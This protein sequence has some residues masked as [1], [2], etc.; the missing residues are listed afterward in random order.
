MITTFPKQTSLA[1]SVHPMTIRRFPA[2]RIVLLGSLLCAFH[3]AD[4]AAQLSFTVTPLRH[5]F[6]KTTVGLGSYTTNVYVTNTGSVDLTVASIA[7]TPSEFQLVT[8][9]F[10][11]TISPGKNTRFGVNFVPDGPKNFSGQLIINITGVSPVIVPLTG[12]GVST[13]AVAGLSS[14]S[15]MFANQTTGTTS[16]SQ[17]VTVSNLGTAPLTVET[18][19][20]DPPF[21]VQ[22]FT[23]P[24]TLQPG[25]AFNFNVT[26]T[27]STVGTFT[28][29]MVISYD[30]LPPNG[31]TLYGNGTA[32]LS[33]AV[34]NLPSLPWATVSSPYLATLTA[35][36]GTAPYSWSLASG[37]SLPLGLTLSSTGTIRGTLDP[38]VQTGS[39]GFDVFATDSSNP[40][41]A[42][43]APVTIPVGALTGADCGNTSWNIGHSTSPLVALNDLGTGTYLGAEA[44]LYPNGSNIRPAA[45]DAAGVAI[46]NSIQPLDGDGNPDPNGKYGLISIGE[47]NTSATFT[48]FTIDAN[49]DPS[50]NSHLTIVKGAQPTGYAANFA[51]PNSSFWNPIFQF[52]LPQAGLTANQVVAVWVQAVNAFPTGLFPSDMTQEQSQLESIAQNLHSKFPNLKLAYYTSKFYDGYDNGLR[53]P[54]YPEPYAY[55][56][57]FAVKWAIQDQIN[58]SAALNYDSNNGPVMAPWM[59]WGP[60]EWANGLLGRSDGLVWSC[61]DMTSDGVHPSSAIGV[62]KDANILLNFFKSDDTTAPWFLAH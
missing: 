45:D 54:R 44:G 55:E 29:A 25:S 4:A 18:I 60:Y 32:P 34:S 17:A 7:I 23:A 49:A 31:V 38:S 15:L 33:F 6:A 46:A 2:V 42:V 14:S 36:G 16:G 35:A 19:T 20:I 50:K 47:S 10:P 37:S 9:W 26:F 56:T 30:V 13:G 39:Y 22:G 1:R 43:T 58:G 61:Q 8:G 53:A 24:T 40:P 51:D 41:N 59:T 3:G 57:G 11:T 48:Q 21:A 27:A 12:T 62:E 52:F 5:Q 28:N